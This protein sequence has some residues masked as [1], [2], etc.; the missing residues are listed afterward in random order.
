MQLLSMFIIN[1]DGNKMNPMSFISWWKVAE[2]EEFIMK[3]GKVEKC[4]ICLGGKE[5]ET[6]SEGSDRRYLVTSSFTL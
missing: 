6:S 1:D 3:V 4:N 2:I 5:K